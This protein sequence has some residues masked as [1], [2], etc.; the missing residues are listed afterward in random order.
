MSVTD[1]A[2]TWS[3]FL[4][5]LSVSEQTAINSEDVFHRAFV[6]VCTELRERDPQR[7]L[8]RFLRHHDQIIAFIGALDESTGLDTSSCLSSVF[9]SKAFETVLTA[10]RTRQ[11]DALLRQYLP[12]LSEITPAFGADLA[13]FPDS[14]KIQKPLQKIFAIYMECY[15]VI[16]QHLVLPSPVEFES[17]LEHIKSASHTIATHKEEWEDLVKQAAEQLAAARQSPTQYSYYNGTMGPLNPYTTRASFEWQETL[18]QG[19]YGQV[20]KVRETSTGTLYAQKVIRVADPRSKSRI[21]KEVI[22]EVS[23]MQKL[24]HHHIASVQFHVFEAD[25]YSI[26]MLPVAECDLRLFLRRCVD[27]QFPRTELTHL[28]S[29]FGCLV[30][31]LAFA[32]SKHIKHE[33]IKP[34]NI[35]IK[36]HQPYLADFGCAKDFSGLDSSTSLD[37]LTFGT[38]VY[39][40]PESQPR[41][42]S[43]DVFSLGC[44]FSEMLTVR[45]KRT[46]EDFQAYRYVHHRDNAYSFKE[47]LDKVIDWL[48]D[49]VPETD[50]VG[51]LL[52][53]QTFKMLERYPSRRKEAKD[54]KRLL[55][56]EGDTVFCSTCF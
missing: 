17:F 43:A 3:T 19:T 15:E 24:R 33:D 23:I 39:W 6:R 8:A 10:L 31:A 12:A 46:L 41:G 29:W 52:K 38:P 22:N 26:I 34:S 4:S 28:T 11:K 53:E 55:R 48:E 35:L 40:A 44:V 45:H 30:G 50:P 56:V 21:E 16:L 42:R 51:T 18:G 2:S 25:T 47:S 27:A 49:I 54:I 5:D 20:S 36:N 37:T 7:L 1:S 14:D 32:H 13:L 9:W